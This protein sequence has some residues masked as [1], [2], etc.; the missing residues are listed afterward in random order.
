MLLGQIFRCDV[1]AYKSAAKA[2]PQI[3]KCSGGPPSWHRFL[4]ELDGVSQKKDVFRNLLE[5]RSPIRMP[6]FRVEKNEPRG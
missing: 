5:V 4:Q 2:G 1:S 6:D 3:K